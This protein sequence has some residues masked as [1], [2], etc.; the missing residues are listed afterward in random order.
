MIDPILA[1]TF[2][3][4]LFVL[5]APLDVAQLP[6]FGGELQQLANQFTAEASQ[7]L[8]TVDNTVIEIT[9]IAYITILLIGVLLYFT[10]LNRRMGRELIIGG[11]VLGASRSSSFRSSVRFEG[12]AEGGHYPPEG[13]DLLSRL[14]RR[15]GRG[16]R[17]LP[18]AR[19]CSGRIRPPPR[20]CCGRRHRRRRCRIYGSRIGGLLHAGEGIGNVPVAAGYPL[21]G[22][23]DEALDLD[24]KAV[25][26]RPFES[27]RT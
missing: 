20:R 18:S 26:A 7:V 16:R 1:P 3:S 23:L 6:D 5:L 4:L 25:A 22:L 24:E 13:G 14:Q 8:L 9:R 11:I 27:R 10:R 2:A 15:V 17:S 12:V 19:S 21:Y